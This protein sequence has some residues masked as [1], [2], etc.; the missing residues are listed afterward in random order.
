MQRELMAL[1][2]NAVSIDK[3]HGH[4][5]IRHRSKKIRDY[6]KNMKID[7]QIEKINEEVNTI[8][9]P[10]RLTKGERNKLEKIV[11]ENC[12]RGNMITTKDVMTHI[13]NAINSKPMNEREIVHTSFRLDTKQYE[14]LSFL[15]KGEFINI[16][17]EEF[18]MNEYKQPDDSFI[19]HHSP[20]PEDVKT[21]P[22]HLDKKVVERIDEIGHNISQAHNRTLTRVKIV[23]DIINQMVNKLESEDPEVMYLQERITADIHSLVSLGGEEALTEIVQQIEKLKS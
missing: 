9:Y 2:V 19:L 7:E 8:F 1:S 10:V 23:R 18:I 5:P 17:I 21:V 11:H 3:F 20:N 12:S 16:S 4:V 13:I 15:L 6:L 22:L 14:R